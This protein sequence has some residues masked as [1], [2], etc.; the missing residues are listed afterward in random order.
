MPLVLA[1]LSALGLL[2]AL[3]GDGSWDV[4]SWMMLGVPVMLCLWYL[5][6]PLSRGIRF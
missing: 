2:S 6:R 1:V 3:L 5:T 4:L